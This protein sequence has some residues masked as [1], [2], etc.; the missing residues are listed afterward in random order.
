MSCPDLPV[1][2]LIGERTKDRQVSVTDVLQRRSSADRLV[3]I[4]WQVGDRVAAKQNCPIAES[5]RRGQDRFTGGTKTLTISGGGPGDDHAAAN[6]DQPPQR[7]RDLAI[8]NEVDDGAL[9]IDTF[10]DI[11][12]LAGLR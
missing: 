2:T 11:D 5:A 6:P 9:L 10:A 3:A 4:E 7:R 8:D 1:A 12:Q